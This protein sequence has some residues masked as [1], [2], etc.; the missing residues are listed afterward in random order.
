MWRRAASAGAGAARQSSVSS[1]SS[2]SRSSSLFAPRR[3]LT[4]HVS[5]MAATQA[6]NADAGLASAPAAGFLSGANSAYVD[7]MYASW[8]SDPSS[9]HPSWSAYFSTGVYTAPPSLG[10]GSVAA[11][12]ASMSGGVV[13]SSLG[14]GATSIAAVKVL[15]LV[16]AFQVRGHLLANLD[17][18]GLMPPRPDHEDLRLDRFGFTD[19]DLDTEIDLSAV[20]EFLH[21]KGFLDKTRGR[22]T[23]RKIYDRLKE[24][25][26]GTIG[27][28]YMHIPSVDKC[29]WIRSKIET[30]DSIVFSKEAKLQLLDRL[31]W[32]DHFEQFLKKRWSS[33]KRFGLEG[34]ESF[35]AGMKSIIG[36]SGELGVENIVIGMP[37]RG[38][39]NVLNTVVRKN[40]AQILSEFNEAHE[41]DPDAGNGDVKYHLGMSYDKS[42]GKSN[43]LIHLSL[44]AN[45]SHL[46]AVDPVVLGKTRAKQF[47]AGDEN[48][49]KMMAVLV[50]GDAAFA[51]QGVVYE[52]FGLS[53]LK[54]Y[55]TGGT[56]HLVVN[57]QVGFTT[58]PV[59]GRSTP[60]CTDIAKYLNAPVFHVNGDDPEAVV[61]VCELA[62]EWR[63]KFKSD[64]V[65]DLVCFRKHG[66]NEIDEPM[67]TQPLM[68]KTVQQHPST[69]QLYQQRCLRDG[70]SESEIKALSDNANRILEQAY[71]ESQH[72][73]QDKLDW[74][75]KNW[76]GLKGHKDYSAPQSTGI[77]MDT[78][79]QIGHHLSRAP[80]GF[81]L[82]SRLAQ[83]LRTKEKAIKAQKDIDWGTAEALAF[84]SLLLE[85]KHVRLSG[86]DV[87]RGT[88]SHRHSVWHDQNT[89]ETYTPLNNLLPGKQA[90]FTVCNSNLSEYAVL[91]FELG[92]SL[93]NPHALV[94]WE[95]QFGDFFNTAQVVVDQFIS[96]GEDKWLRQSGLVM[97]LPH[98]Y[99]GQGPEHSSARVER[100]LQQ[101]ND[102]PDVIP[103][104]DKSHATQQA[105]WQI[106][107]CTTPANYFHVLR[108]QLHRDFRKPLVVMSPKSLLRAP[109]ARST[110]A[111]MATGTAFRKVIAESG[112]GVEMVPDE[113]VER[114][115][116]SSGKVYYDLLQRR[117]DSKMGNVAL[118]RVEQISPF[119]FHEVAE[120]LKRYPNAQIVWCQEEPMNMGA[121]VYCKDRIITACEQLCGRT[122]VK[123]K[124]V[125]RQPSAATA[126]GHLYSHKKE[127]EAFLK[128]AFTL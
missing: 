105:N 55:T 43:K 52:C 60:Y 110:F 4:Q 120:Q 34:A 41:D 48:R 111:D 15:H 79:A 95:A 85:N 25:Y 10:G 127:L 87:E 64:V 66:H 70:I 123:V 109:F 76:K 53:N 39:L 42:A 1:L 104:P 106:V 89:N 93:E 113:K 98:G 31:T 9:V 121:Y 72:F 77:D 20:G 126:A 90:H 49:D 22:V 2:L 8:L 102:R 63:Q 107:N 32:A 51:G 114:V 103:P 18:L 61:H 108:R 5:R 94:L 27:Y 101:C 117:T 65:I 23:L 40:L 118:I 88:F 119:P 91:G 122:N 59:S 6:N 71:E 50:H 11:A 14:S 38:R 97:L 26:C 47:Y 78:L 56:I 68:Y 12:G 74:L 46:E 3:S 33:A 128:D 115:I 35:I 92:Y 13:P 69:L 82:H 19:A 44:M 73:K 112:E 58:D 96:S 67:F 57:N 16:R 124:Y 80:E 116:L 30:R 29:N 125:G 81:A 7:A 75:A 45:P 28:E 54:N 86:Q 37:H 99:E 17:P 21:M 24:T 83:V 100:F 62:S 36:K 84:G